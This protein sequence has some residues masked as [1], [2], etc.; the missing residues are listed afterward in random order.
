MSLGSRTSCGALLVGLIAMALTAT[1]A[2]A[3]LVSETAHTLIRGQQLAEAEFVF[4]GGA[5]KCKTR[6]I[7]GTTSSSTVDE[8]T[9]TPIFGQCLSGESAATVETN[10]CDVVLS[11]TEPPLEGNVPHWY[12]PGGKKTTLKAPNCEWTVPPQT[13]PKVSVRYHTVG[14]GKNHNIEVTEIFDG[15]T[16]EKHGLC[17]F[18]IPP[19]GTGPHTNG[20]FINKWTMEGLDTLGSQVPITAT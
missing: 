14:T 2:S 3:H 10:G 4:P 16:Y 8:V 12:C 19:F 6:D 15:L 7:E 18:V 11:F 13:A 1:G 9:L 20:R 17:A 5:I